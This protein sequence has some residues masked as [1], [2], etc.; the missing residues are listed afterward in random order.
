[1][2]FGDG[3][4]LTVPITASG[5]IGLVLF[6]GAM[7]QEIGLRVSNS[8]IGLGV[9]KILQPNGSELAS[10][11]FSTWGFID[12]Q[13]LPQ[14]GTYAIVLDP[15]STYTGEA[16]LILMNYP[17]AGRMNVALA[18]NG[19]EISA[20]SVYASGYPAS[21]LTN[22]EQSVATGPGRQCSQQ[23]IRLVSVHLRARDHLAHSRLHYGRTRLVQP[24][25]GN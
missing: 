3:E 17:Q 21:S 22:G 20:S 4:A 9:L 6:E 14:Q 5:K 18:S 10:G 8:S 11:S 13:M 16:T 15:T 12:R 24:L 7:G 2:G 19:A 23:H 25:D 1:M